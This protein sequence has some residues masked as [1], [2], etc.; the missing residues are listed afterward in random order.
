MTVRRLRRRYENEKGQRR[1]GERGGGQEGR[2]VRYRGEDGVAEL[3]AE[4][5]R[6]E[7]WQRR[8]WWMM[9]EGEPIVLLT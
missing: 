7:G 4:E 2:K 3:S 6:S 9:Q 1:G 8:G 5:K